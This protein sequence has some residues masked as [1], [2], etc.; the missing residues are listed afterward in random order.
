MAAGALKPAPLQEVV[1]HGQ[2][3]FRLL[4]PL[5]DHVLH[6]KY[7]PLP[8]NESQKRTSFG[9]ILVQHPK[10]NDER[11]YGEFP[12]TEPKSMTDAGSMVLTMDRAA[13]FASS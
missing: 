5:F 12:A 3:L 7:L 10:W 13:F 11:I 9:V 8:G 6:V 1:G 4:A 2:F